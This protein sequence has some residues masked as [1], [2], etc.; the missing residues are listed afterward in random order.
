M[1]D[2][3]AFLMTKSWTINQAS[4]RGNI[5]SHVSIV[6]PLVLNKEFGTYVNV[7]RMIMI[8]SK[9]CSDNFSRKLQKNLPTEEVFVAIGAVLV[10]LDTVKLLFKYVLGKLPFIIDCQQ[11][12]QEVKVVLFY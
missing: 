1:L 3:K 2:L 6:V 5:I 12:W 8:N 4:R 10:V 7:H 9:I 11:S